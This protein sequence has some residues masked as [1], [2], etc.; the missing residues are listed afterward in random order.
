MRM[1]KMWFPISQGDS[2]IMR[3]E[4]IKELLEHHRSELISADETSV[5]VTNGICYD[6][7]VNEELFEQ[8]EK[9]VFLLKETNGNDKKGNAQSSYDDWNYRAWLEYQ[10][11]KNLEEPSYGDRKLYKTF[12][13]LAMWVDLF[14]SKTR[15]DFQEYVTEDG[16]SEENLR[17]QLGK[18]A[19]INLKKTWGG[20]TTAWK[21]LNNYLKNSCIKEVLKNE[22]AYV[23][24][25]IVVCGSTEVY[26]FAKKIFESD[27]EKTIVTSKKTVRVFSYQNMKFVE[28]YHPACRKSRE[29]LYDFCREVVDQL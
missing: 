6:G 28:F 22:L 17:Y 11:H 29:F 27:A 19:V 26:E 9:I 21:S 18:A 12:Y 8:S 4:K 16:L 25:K 13:N 1:W 3:N 23:E 15:V 5:L 2:S 20:A 10:Q 7:I 14:N 24:P